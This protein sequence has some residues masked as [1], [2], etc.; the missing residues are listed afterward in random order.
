MLTSTFSYPSCAEMRLVRVSI[1]AKR[2]VYGS[3]PAGWLEA[4]VFFHINAPY[5]STN[6]PYRTMVRKCIAQANIA[7][8]HESVTFFKS[9]LRR[10]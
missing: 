7:F 8:A 4:A 3:F 1:L 6:L 5:T 2:Q 9:R 10:L